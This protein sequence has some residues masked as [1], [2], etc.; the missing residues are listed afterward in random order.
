M[1]LVLP[2]V[3]QEGVLFLPLDLREKL[4]INPSVPD[5]CS[6]GASHKNGG[7]PD[8][9]SDREAQSSIKFTVVFRPKFMDIRTNLPH[10]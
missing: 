7:F 6:S 2:P 4:E 9:Q 8:W 3:T 5:S 1:Q 10:F